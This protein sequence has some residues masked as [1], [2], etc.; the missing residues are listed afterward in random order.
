M[1]NRTVSAPTQ[2]YWLIIFIPT[3]FSAIF[4][5]GSVISTWSSTSLEIKE[6]DLLFT[7]HRLVWLF[8][9]LLK[10]LWVWLLLGS[11][12]W[13]REPCWQWV[14][15]VSMATKHTC[16]V[17]TATG[18]ICVSL[19]SAMQRPGT[20]THTHTHTHRVRI[21]LNGFC[22]FSQFSLT[23][24]TFVFCFSPA[25]RKHRS[26]HDHHRQHGKPRLYLLWCLESHGAAG[27][28]HQGMSR[29]GWTKWQGLY[30]DQATCQHHQCMSKKG[31]I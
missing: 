13:T 28:Q 23:A 5:Q 11:S 9:V 22:F 31:W 18:N 7:L 19:S 12:P 4:E 14:P 30:C 27:Q 15:S 26:L 24:N 3:V 20:H 8:R 25:D 17:S 1:T 6:I 16:P 21:L 2:R 10:H 29:T